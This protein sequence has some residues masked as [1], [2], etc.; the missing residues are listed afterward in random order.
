MAVSLVTVL[1]DLEWALKGKKA[2]EQMM[3]TPKS[4]PT[5]DIT[6]QLYNI[7]FQFFEWMDQGCSNRLIQCDSTATK[8]LSSPQSVEA[9]FS[10]KNI[11]FYCSGKLNRKSD[12]FFVKVRSSDNFVCSSSFALC[13]F[14]LK[15]YL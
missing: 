3:M 5:T 14:G 6:L 4:T 9:Y 15:Q 1:V 11:Q 8:C 13:L 10:R 12:S 7:Y 2:T